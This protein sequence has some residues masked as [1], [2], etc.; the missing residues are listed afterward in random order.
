MGM[1]LMMVATH[2]EKIH[3][4]GTETTTMTSVFLSATQNTGS[5]ASSL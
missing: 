2:S 1:R 5:F 3:V 4:T